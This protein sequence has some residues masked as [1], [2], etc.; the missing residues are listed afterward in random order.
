M[1]RDV[2]SLILEAGMRPEEVFRV[3]PEDLHLDQGYLFNPYGKTKAAKRRIKL[4]AL[5]HF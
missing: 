3:R 4:T 1:L 2:A 5:E